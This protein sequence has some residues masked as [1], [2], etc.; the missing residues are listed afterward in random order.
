MR[1]TELCPSPHLEALDV[2]DKIGDECTV[3]IKGVHIADV[4]QEK[5]KKG[6]VVFDEFDRGL[7]LNKT[8]SRMI[9]SIHGAQTDSWK[10]KKL[11]LYRSETSFQNKTVPCIRVK[12]AVKK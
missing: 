11:V 6:V 3:T 2:G 1:V 9:A 7:V 8:N 5:V 10:G 12:E 4:G